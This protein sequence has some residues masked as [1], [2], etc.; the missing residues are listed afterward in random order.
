MKVL[1]E[2]RV[3][4]SAIESSFECMVS[5]VLA[6]NQISFI[7]DELPPEGR[8]HTLP[9]HIMLKR[10]NMIISRVL[11]DNG[12]TPNVCAISTIEIL[13]IDTSLELLMAL[14]RRCKARSS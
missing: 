10:E 14:S 2:M 11:I 3:P 5:M 7:D 13:N 12:S 4:T 1:K 6:T 8:E 9:M